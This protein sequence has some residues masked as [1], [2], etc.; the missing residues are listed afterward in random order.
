[1]RAPEIFCI[2]RFPLRRPNPFDAVILLLHSQGV[3]MFGSY[4]FG[5]TEGLKKPYVV[6]LKL[7]QN[8][9]LID[10]SPRVIQKGGPDFVRVFVFP[11]MQL[12]SIT[13]E[14]LIRGLIDWCSDSRVATEAVPKST[15]EH[16]VLSALALAVMGQW[17]S[18][19]KLRDQ[20]TAS[21]EEHARSESGQ[22]TKSCANTH[23]LGLPVD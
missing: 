9:C 8:R 20:I 5:G 22:P 21:P 16:W 14:C 15:G 6:Q 23:K 7:T 19:G 3:I 18:H 17:L 13:S 2:L 12:Q 4:D 10:L 11:R 1:M